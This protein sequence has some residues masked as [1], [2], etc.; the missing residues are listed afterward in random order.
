[1]S[2]ITVGLNRARSLVAAL[3]LGHGSTMVWR[4]SAVREAVG[5]DRLP[6]ARHGRVAG[7]GARPLS[8]VVSPLSR[9]GARKADRAA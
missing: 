1:M 4:G 6:A 9:V 7:R 8:R 2:R 5:D 3:A